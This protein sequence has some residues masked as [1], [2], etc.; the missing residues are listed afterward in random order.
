[1][2]NSHHPDARTTATHTRVHT[3]LTAAAEKRLLV[4]IAQRLPRRV[5]SDHLTLLGFASSLGVAAAFAATRWW[6]EAPYLVVPFLVLNWLGDSLDGTLARVRDEQRPRYGFYVDH[7]IDV[8]GVAALAGGLA[9]S[10][11]MHPLLALAVGLAY[12]L[13]A[14]ESFL[15]THAL[16][17]FRMS[18]ALFGPTELRI[19]LALGATKVAGSP[20]TTLPGIGRVGVF[21]LGGVVAVAGMLLALTVSAARHAQELYRLE[22]PERRLRRSGVQRSGSSEVLEVSTS[23]LPGPTSDRQDPRGSEPLTLCASA[24]PHFRTQTELVV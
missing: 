23:K 10:G 11:L 21:D 20:W 12:V 22:T 2:P 4:W 13:L 8:V 17:V 18:F 14:A 5:N 19:V 6:P 24:P 16:G 1:M 7:V 9:A 3:S 15:A